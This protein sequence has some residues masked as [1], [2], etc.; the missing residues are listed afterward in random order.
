ML[1]KLNAPYPAPRPDRAA[2]MASLFMAGFVTV[3][4][5]Y[6]QPFGLEGAPYYGAIGKIGFFGLITLVCFLFLEVLFPL[7]V[8]TWFNDRQ[9]KVWHRIAYYLFLL[10]LIA[11]MNGLYVNYIGD[12]GFKWKNYG[13]I[14]T[15]TLALGILPVTIIVLYRYNEKMAF[16]LQQAA[17]VERAS[18]LMPKAGSPAPEDVSSEVFLAAEAYG[19]YVKVY[20][21]SPDSWKQ[22]VQRETLSKLVDKL[23]PTGVIRCHR[24]FAVAPQQVKHVSGNAQGLQLLVGKGELEI[25]VSRTYL[26]AVREALA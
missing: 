25:P 12:L 13:T 21:A 16:Y 2:A 24:S 18:R 19:N 17:E 14:L 11:S 4:L 1:A 10:W 5:L 22:E 9:W 7:L 15:Q 3:F 26:K 20:Y 23:S 8:P 6:F